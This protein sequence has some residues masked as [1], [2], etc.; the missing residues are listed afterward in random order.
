MKAGRHSHQLSDPFTDLLFNT[1][2]GFTLLFF[3]SIIFMNPIAKLGNINYKAEYI[4]TVIWPENQPDDIDLWVQDPYHET[5][6]YLRKEAGWLH[7]DR[8]DRGDLNDTVMINGEKVV[9]PINQEVVTIRGIISGEY[10]VNLHYYQSQ[11]QQPVKA[12][13]KIEKVN[14]VLRLVFIDQVTLEQVDD[15]KTVLRFE[16]DG[17]GEIVG[18]NRV[19]KT[20]TP[21]RLDPE[22]LMQDMEQVQ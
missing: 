3:I 18:M 21:Y 15:E 4:I 17:N 12:N 11:S 14:P 6:S 1:L 2:L 8:D 19:A 5:V 13:V 20:L 22:Q 7:L 16:L 9:H 10:I